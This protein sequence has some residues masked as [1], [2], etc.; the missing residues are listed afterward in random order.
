MDFKRQP[1]IGDRKFLLQ[2]FDNTFAD[3]TKG[4]DVVGIDSDF[5]RFHRYFLLIIADYLIMSFNER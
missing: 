3:I 5:Y 2:P 4:S 1:F